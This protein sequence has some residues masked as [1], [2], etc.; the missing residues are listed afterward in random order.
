MQR[1]WLFNNKNKK[2]EQ[3]QAGR[4]KTG[5]QSNTKLTCNIRHT[6]DNGSAQDCR[7]K[8]NTIGRQT[9]VTSGDTA[10]AT[11]TMIK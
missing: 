2:K 4:Q 8:E 5:A 9:R 7:H 11:E 10:G 6:K 3:K 1:K